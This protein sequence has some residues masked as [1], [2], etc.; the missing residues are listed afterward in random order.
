[1]QKRIGCLALA[2]WLILMLVPAAVLASGSTYVIVG[3]SEL[4][5]SLWDMTDPGNEMTDNGDGTYTTVFTDVDVY[6]YYQL[7][8]VQIPEG[9]DPIWHGGAD[10]SIISF[11]VNTACD[12]TVNFDAATNMLMMSGEGVVM[13]TSDS[14]HPLRRVPYKPATVTEDGNIEHWR[15]ARCGGYFS[16]ETGKN[17]IPAISIILSKLAPEIIEGRGQSVTAGEKKALAFRSNAAFS[18]FFGVELDG[19]T[20]AAADYTAKEGSTVVT[21]KP[22]CVAALS[23]GEHTI[24][25]V[26]D[27]GTAACTFTVRAAQAETGPDIPDSDVLDHVPKTGDSARLSLWVALLLVS[28]CGLL[29][30]AALA[31]RK[32]RVG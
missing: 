23:V 1:M 30:A 7:M 8:V 26:S 13:V 11:L 15:C 28:V 27:G 31:K 12:V 21:L 4:C 10:G 17:E 14:N 29:G 5:G 2:L 22:E 16:D 3:S 25:V 6:D 24:G 20:L 19:A 18:D 9:G 32:N